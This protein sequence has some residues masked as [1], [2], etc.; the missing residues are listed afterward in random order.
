ML[1]ILTKINQL[2]SVCDIYQRKLYLDGEAWGLDGIPS[3]MIPSWKL[4][5]YLIKL[6]HSKWSFRC[7]FRETK[8]M[9]LNVFNL[10]KLSIIAD[11]SC[12][13][14]HFISL[15]TY[16]APCVSEAQSSAQQRKTPW[17]RLVDCCPLL[18]NSKT[19]S[20]QWEEFCQQHKDNGWK[21]EKIAPNMHHLWIKII[22][23]WDQK[24]YPNWPQKRLLGM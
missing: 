4:G 12:W 11:M 13:Q 18:T 9:D 14:Q 6:F 7:G 8:K 10:W 2:I 15:H 16:S 19:N 22:T 20:R 5:K 24:D 23:A 1:Y 3:K 17:G 21:D